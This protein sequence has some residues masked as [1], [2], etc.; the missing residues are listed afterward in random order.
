MNWF[1]LL[2]V[3][4]IDFDSAI[5]GF[6]HYVMGARSLTFEE[7][8]NTLSAKMGIG[9]LDNKK[10]SDFTHERIRINHHE[11]YTYLK[12]KLGKE[13]TEKQLAMYITRVIMHEGTHAGMGLEQT[14]QTTAQSEYGAFVGQFPE[15]MYMRMKAFLKHPASNNYTVP[16]EV[17]E[18]YG[19]PKDSPKFVEV[20][21]DTLKVADG[22]A[23]ND[24]DKEK[25]V[26]LEALARK[27]NKPDLSQ[28]DFM[29]LEVLVDRWG[30]ENQPFIEEL[31]GTRKSSPNS[32]NDDTEKMTGAVTTSSAPSMFNTSYSGK[33]KKDDE[34]YA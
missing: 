24:K 25:I 9:E 14:N 27:K 17:Y 6:G 33:K 2:K 23:N 20:I 12:E 26:Q 21:E 28:S 5:S 19:F 32:N 1:S 7:I 11:V 22:L 10:I 31:L 18:A 30:K 29:Q 3:E 8:L 4:D 16:P 15:S 34:E 13:P